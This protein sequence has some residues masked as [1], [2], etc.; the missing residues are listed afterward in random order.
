MAS[1]CAGCDQWSINSWAKAIGI[2]RVITAALQQP[3]VAQHGA[4]DPSVA[5]AH[6]KSLA[7]RDEVAKLVRT[8][9]LAEA[10]VDLVW[11]HVQ[12][13]HA[14]T[15][16]P[17]TASMQNKFAGAIELSYGG[18]DTFF[19]GLEAQVGSPNPKVWQGLLSEHTAGPDATREFVTGNY[20]IRTTSAIEWRFVTSADPAAAL[21]KLG[22]ASWPAESTEKL[23]D[24]SKCRQHRALADLLS[25]AE[26]LNARL[27]AADQPPM[28]KEEVVATSLYT[29]PL[30]TK[31]NA[32]LRCLRSNSTFLQNAAVNLCCASDVAAAYAAGSLSFNK[33]LGSL[34]KYT[35]TLHCANSA[36]I[37]L[38]KLTNAAPVYR[39]VAG[40][41]LPP[42]FWTP[43]EF[44]VK[45]GASRE[46]SL[47][48][49]TFL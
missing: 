47:C 10:I 36:I 46:S 8:D 14:A 5:F 16:P 45:G 24:R 22:L 2:H 21:S 37:K 48:L 42:E 18:L 12:E 41:A 33:A 40:L 1:L 49:H 28:R 32:V 19:G 31:Y 25:L 17:T 6:V 44:G 9:V 29:G 35:S 39:G 38:G 23:P 3:L 30:F 15:E 20:G 11:Q 7:S 43:N 4:D 27:I 13:L 26:P 34:N